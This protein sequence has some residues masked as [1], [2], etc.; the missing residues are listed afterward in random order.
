MTFYSKKDVY[1]VSVNNVN[2]WTYLM[3]QESTGLLFYAILV[4][5]KG[6]RVHPYK[7]VGG[8]LTMIVTEKVSNETYNKVLEA[9]PFAI[10]KLNK[11]NIETLYR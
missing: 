8:N 5:G 7:P 9:I 4:Y 6:V 10:L 2:S 11:L 3:Y 1:V